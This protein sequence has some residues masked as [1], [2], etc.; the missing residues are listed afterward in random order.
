MS[1]NLVTGDNTSARKNRSKV[2]AY[3]HV[4]LPSGGDSNKKAV[5]DLGQNVKNV[6]S[7]VKKTIHQV[8]DIAS[9]LKKHVDAKLNAHALQTTASLG[10]LEAQV[11][12]HT[13]KH[14]DDVAKLKR[15]AAHAD[16][17]CDTETAKLKKDLHGLH[18]KH[19][20][21]L[22]KLKNDL[23]EPSKKCDA[24]TAKLK[25]ELNGLHKKHEAELSKL[26]VL[27]GSLTNKINA[28]NKRVALLEGD[29]KK[30][31]IHL[32]KDTFVPPQPESKKSSGGVWE[33]APLAAS[34]NGG[35]S[36]FN[37]GYTK[38]KGYDVTIDKD[39]GR[40]M[41]YTPK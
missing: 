17:K 31:Y 28:L 32:G 23:I 37:I 10:K 19:E 38:K 1:S 15:D 12:L 6:A 22:A 26:E 11:S 39:S 5:H 33:T 8:N 29:K 13:K 16:K 9:G 40:L 36:L 25:K 18:K 20:A 2:D 4:M 7:S 34:V 24:E 30:D 14:G 35:L 27:V 41:L 3:R 21:D